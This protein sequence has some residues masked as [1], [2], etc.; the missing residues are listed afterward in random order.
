MF[1]WRGRVQ[2]W[3]PWPKFFGKWPKKFYSKSESNFEKVFLSK[4][5][6]LF[7]KFFWTGRM[8]F[9]RNC[10]KILVKVE[11]SSVQ[12]PKKFKDSNFF[13]G[14][15]FSQ[16]APLD[17]WKAVP[18]SLPTIF[19]QNSRNSFAQAIEIFKEWK[20]NFLKNFFA[21]KFFRTGRIQFWQ[22]WRKSF[23]KM[24][25][26]FCLKSEVIMKIT[27]VFISFLIFQIV[28]WTHR[29]QFWKPCL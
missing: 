25:N 16:N 1:Q 28:F 24:L 29:K 4:K 11:N 9:W 7:K 3:Q 12:F 23:A 26:I 8:Q 2:V 20:K 27:I 5:I 21:K 22:A 17:T 14:K 19:S 15:S 18:T 6:F 10:R 13:T